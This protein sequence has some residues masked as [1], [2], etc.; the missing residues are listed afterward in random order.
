[1]L[2]QDLSEQVDSCRWRQMCMCVCVEGEAPALSGS[3]FRFGEDEKKPSHSLL[4]L[5]PVDYTWSLQWYLEMCT[6]FLKHVF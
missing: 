2:G 6:T 3:V 1:M 4:L 5:P